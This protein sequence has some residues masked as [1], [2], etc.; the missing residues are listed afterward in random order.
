VSDASSSMPDRPCLHASAGRL[1]DEYDLAVVDLD[2]TV[3]VG[4]DPVPGATQA[5]RDLVGTGMRIAFVTNNA[6]RTPAQVARVLDQMGIEAGPEDVVTSAQAAADIVRTMVPAG[7]PVLV[8][9]GRGIQEALESQGLRPVP[10]ADDAP[11]AVVQ[12]WTPELDWRMLAE[13][14]LAL[15]RGLPW[16]ATNTDLTV[17]TGRGIAPGNGSFVALLGR[18][19]GRSPDVVAGKPGVALLEQTA[20]RYRAARPLVVGD[21]LD[22]DVA[23]AHAAGM[24]S[25]L[26]L[27]GVT[28]A[29][30]LLT[31]APDLRPTYVGS[32]VG[33]LLTAHPGAEARGSTF[34]SGAGSV[35]V[36]RS[37]GSPVVDVA[38]EVDRAP[39]DADP[40]DADPPDA[41]SK[42]RAVDVLRAA[43]LAT[44]G[45]LDEGVPVSLGADLR[46]LLERIRPGAVRP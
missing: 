25:L 5:L 45:L 20:R 6:A 9:G 21:R 13:G 12:G 22:T 40:P 29:E 33:A 43:A 37:G 30:D 14:A 23:G 7:A 19:V 16:I 18:V 2:G 44:W 35:T 1:C 24:D 38:T 17:P 4:R 31:A 32:D 42:D 26:V 8:V 36:D 10:S 34:V 3:Y 11:V 46:A 28:S 15:A 39:S 41:D 27:S